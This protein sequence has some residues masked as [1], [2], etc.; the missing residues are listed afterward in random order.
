[1][2]GRVLHERVHD[3]DFF[4]ARGGVLTARSV[5]L[6]SYRLGLYG[7][8]DAVEFCTA[9]KGKGVELRGR[10]GWW[11]PVP[12]EYKR[13]SPKKDIMDELQLC[14]QGIC[15]EEMV[16]TQ[17]AF[18]YLFYGETRRRTKVAFDSTLRE[19]VVCYSAQMHACFDGKITPE[20]DPE[21]KNCKACSLYDVC[22][23][24]LFKKKQSVKGYIQKSMEQL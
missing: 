12:V 7:V 10:P 16:D 18:G 19:H 5:P 23:P 6:A 8:S 11:Q 9:P 4:E 21:Y 15:L 2:E 17:I 3:S 1:M 14:S 13:G 20:P 24:K 22:L